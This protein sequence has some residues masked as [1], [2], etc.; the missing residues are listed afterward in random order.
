MMSIKDR[1]EKSPGIWLLSVAFSAFVL[2][3]SAFPGLLKIA[4]RTIVT[5]EL[6]ILGQ[7]PSLYVVT[8]PIDASVSLKQV[9][10]DYFPGIRLKPGI[11]TIE[12][13]APGHKTQKRKIEMNY[14]DQRIFVTLDPTFDLELTNAPQSR[15]KGPPMTMDFVNADLRNI[16]RV[17]GEAINLNVIWGP[18]IRGTVSLRY[19]Q[20]PIDQVLYTLSVYFGFSVEQD[21]NVIMIRKKEKLGMGKELCP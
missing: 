18:D 20:V 7:N 21:G 13:S 3:F 4:G 17:I 11:Y 14:C 16:F 9:G 12:I 15:F 10:Q 6:G 19:K 1:I 8:K 2:G 5:A